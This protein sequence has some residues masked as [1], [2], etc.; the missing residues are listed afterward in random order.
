MFR[1]EM[2]RKES[3]SNRTAEAVLRTAAGL[4]SALLNPGELVSMGARIN[5]FVSKGCRARE[6]VSGAMAAGELLPA[7]F[8]TTKLV[9]AVAGL[10]VFVSSALTESRTESRSRMT[11]DQ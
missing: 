3:R 2:M 8:T 11:N 6:F 1:S 7:G 4:V 10:R 9:S 5:E